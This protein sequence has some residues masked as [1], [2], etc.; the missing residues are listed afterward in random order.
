MVH[1]DKGYE[2]YGRYDE[3]GRNLRPF[4]K[5]FQECGIDSQYT[6]S[7][8]PQHNGI[9][10]MR[11]RRFLDMARYMLINSSLPDFLWGKDL[12]TAA[13]IL[14]QAPSKFVIRLYMGIKLKMGLK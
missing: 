6:M 9:A 4:A 12:K 11:K 5:Y 13:N 8:I 1:S 2:Y 7:G 3:T 14:N 10:E